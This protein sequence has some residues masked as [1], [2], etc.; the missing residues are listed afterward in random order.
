MKT[1]LKHSSEKSLT[2]V[3]YSTSNTPNNFPSRID[4][5]QRI[6]Q[7]S[8]KEQQRLLSSSSLPRL[9]H[10][11]SGKYGIRPIWPSDQSV[12]EQEQQTR[13]SSKNRWSS[14]A[15]ISSRSDRNQCARSKSDLQKKFILPS[16]STLSYFTQEDGSKLALASVSLLLLLILIIIYIFYRRRCTK[17]NGNKLNEHRRRQS[18]EDNLLNQ[19]SLEYCLPS[20]RKLPT[21]TEESSSKLHSSNS[22]NKTTSISNSINVTSLPTVTDDIESRNSP[23]TSLRQPKPLADHIDTIEKSLQKVSTEEQSTSSK[24]TLNEQSTPSKEQSTTLNQTSNEKQSTT[25]NLPSKV[26]QPTT[27]KS[28]SQEQSTTKNLPPKVEQ[29]TTSKSPSKEPSATSNLPP[30]VEQPT[31]SKSPSK[32]Q[33]ATPNLPP[34]VE[35]PTTQIVPSKVE[36]PTTSKSSSTEQSA[37]PNLPSKVEQP[38]TPIVPSKVEQP[39]TSKSPSKEQSTT[40]NLPPKVEQPTT[41]KPPF[42]V[43]QPTTSNQTPKEKQSTAPTVSPKVEQLGTPKP[44]SKEQSTTPSIPSKVEQAAALKST[45][46]EQAAA[47]KSASKE[48]AAAPKSASKEQAAAPKSTSKEQSITPNP[49]SKLEQSKALNLPPSAEQ[50]VTSNS[51]RRSRFELDPKTSTAESSLVENVLCPPVIVRKVSATHDHVIKDDFAS[52]DEINNAIKEV[53]LDHSQLIFGIDY[54]I[55]NLE[56]GK[57]SFNG[58]SLHHIQDGLLNPYQSVITIVGR[59]LEKYDSDKLIPVFGFGDRSTLDRKIFPLRP[60]GS[61]CKGFRGVLEAYNEITPKV[62]MSGPTN[63][64]PLI[65]EAVRIVKKTGEYHI[66]VIVADGQVTNERQT[67][68][69]IVEAS[70]YPLSIVMIGVGDGPWDMMEEFDDS[71]P[72][73][74]FDNFQ[75]VDYHSVFEASIN[76]DSTF[77]LRALMEIPSQYAQI[78]KLGLLNK[79]Y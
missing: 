39:T 60:D 51:R 57:T 38:T 73:R 45:S 2:K 43:A 75:F 44:P 53:G 76:T 32:E 65:R 7:P 8:I 25:S 49:P 35:Q 11:H 41:P 18:V 68:D 54:T 79:K 62:R 52:L 55:S 3:F 15:S 58:L 21:F 12:C 29:P 6:V 46:K 10:V 59:T 23:S 72:T 69:A 9:Q 37:T 56:T 63:F 48:Q 34:N 28:T 67:K 26:E 66:L 77:A 31:T 74:Q 50:P 42:K 40:S 36:Q 33:S 64:A 4:F 22:S 30:E 24:T 17:I 71:L 1:Y 20:V 5:R 14:F 16:T 27:S 19:E 70:N 78:K 61:Y 13:K 47:P